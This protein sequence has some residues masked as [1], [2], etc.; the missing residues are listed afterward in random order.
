MH[1]T[2]LY[3]YVIVN[4]G[5]PRTGNDIDVFLEPLI[6]ELKDLWDNGATTYDAF[7]QVNFLM[8]AAIMWTIND[9]P[10]YANLSGWSTKGKNACPNCHYETD[11]TWL[12]HGK[13]LCYRGHRRHLPMSH[14]FR[15]QHESFNLSTE[16]RSAPIP[17]TGSE[18]L[19]RLSTLTFSFGKPPPLKVGEKRP[20]PPPHQDTPLRK[21]SIFFKLPYWEHLLIRHNLDVMHVE[22]NVFDSVIGTLLGIP[23]KSKD[24]INARLDMEL[25]GIKEGLWPVREGNVTRLP[26]G[27]F[28]LKNDE[29]ELICKVLAS[30]ILPD[31]RASNISRNVH[32]KERTIHGLKSHDCHVIMQELLPVAIRHALPPEMTKILLELSAYFRHLYSKKGSVESFH[33]LTSVITMILC[34]LERIMPPAFFDVMVH[35]TIHLAEEAA[36]AGPVQYRCMWPIERYVTYN[37]MCRHIYSICIRQLG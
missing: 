32:V 27:L 23:G 33:K 1:E 11:A 15:Q 8:R 19:E 9:F 28:S 30:A 20:P 12:T 34:Q 10:A 18:C 35:V 7:R 31:G 4:P 2:T 25:M 3:F 37:L 5:T 6:D 21:C 26:M 22:K 14:P 24:S 13:K 16:M 36:L 17:L 29:K